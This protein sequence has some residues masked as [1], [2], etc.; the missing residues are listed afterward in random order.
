MTEDFNAKCGYN[1][2]ALI[3]KASYGH[4]HLGRCILRDLGHFG[5]EADITMLIDEKCTG[6]RSCTVPFRITDPEFERAKP[7]C[8][9]GLMTFLEAKY[10]CIKGKF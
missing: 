10:I 6:K 8:A 5:C 9:E 1:E 7:D 3:T 4:L 2:V